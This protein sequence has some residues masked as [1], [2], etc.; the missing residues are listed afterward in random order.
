M[1]YFLGFPRFDT[2][3]LTSHKQLSE[4]CIC[5]RVINYVLL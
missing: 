5:I 1:G 2:I 4:H 3:P